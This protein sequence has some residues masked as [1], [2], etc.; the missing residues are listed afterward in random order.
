MVKDAK[1]FCEF[2]SPQNK[3]S[4][5]MTCYKTAA[6]RRL[7]PAGRRVKAVRRVGDACTLDQIGPVRMGTWRRVDGLF[8]G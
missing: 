1:D 3:H 4:L 8:F 2:F 6:H 5:K 7:Q